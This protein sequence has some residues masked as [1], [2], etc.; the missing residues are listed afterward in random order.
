MRQ[1]PAADTLSVPVTQDY[2]NL[3]WDAENKVPYCEMTHQIQPSAPLSKKFT[4]KNASGH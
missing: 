1:N 4:M 3:D 2:E